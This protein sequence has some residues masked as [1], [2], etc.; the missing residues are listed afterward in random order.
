MTLSCLA[1]R[2][3]KPHNLVW[4]NKLRFCAFFY[5]HLTV[6]KLPE[7]KCMTGGGPAGRLDWQ[8]KSARPIW[9]RLDRYYIPANVWRLGRYGI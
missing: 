4:L 6:Y 8:I 9:S 7:E 3:L 2:A 5:E 1:T